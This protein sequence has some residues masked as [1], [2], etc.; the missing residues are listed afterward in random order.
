M[1]GTARGRSAGGAGGLS[2][3]TQDCQA[4]RGTL[5]TK[6]VICRP[7]DPEAKGLV[8]RL[9]DELER[10]FLPGRNFTGPADFKLEARMVV[11]GESLCRHPRARSSV[12]E[13]LSSPG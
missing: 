13:P 6:V 4:F 11:R 1:S 7:A 5:A 9:H 2:E 3:L 10:S 8:E 12:A